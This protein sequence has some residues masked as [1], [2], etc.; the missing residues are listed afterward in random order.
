[1]TITYTRTYSSPMVT[2]VG[3]LLN[4]VISFQCMITG[5]DDDGNSFS[6]NNRVDLPTVNP[7]KFV[8]FDDLTKDIF[9]TWANEYLNIESIELDISNSI[10][11]VV[12][13]RSIVQKALPF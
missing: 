3:N 2:T 12:N 1:M 5:E 11:A 7:T 10:Q 8:V 9:D 4:V 6:Y 13:S